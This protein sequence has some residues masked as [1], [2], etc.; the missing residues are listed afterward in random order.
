MTEEKDLKMSVREF[1]TMIIATILIFVFVGAGIGYAM[2]YDQLKE[3][4]PDCNLE[5]P[6]VPDPKYEELL[7]DIWEIMNMTYNITYSPNVTVDID[8]QAII[9]AIMNSELN[10]SEKMALYTS[11]LFGNS[12]YTNLIIW[13]IKDGMQNAFFYRYPE[14]H[15]DIEFYVENVSVIIGYYNNSA[16]W[17]AL[18]PTFGIENWSHIIDWMVATYEYDRNTLTQMQM[19]QLTIIA[20][21]LAYYKETGTWLGE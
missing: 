1:A 3:D 20:M 12:N 19:L 14:D 7:D 13:D 9:D 5:C 21:D 10:I 8:N 18:T 2:T 16:D 15:L 4:C 11:W 6:D 17:Y